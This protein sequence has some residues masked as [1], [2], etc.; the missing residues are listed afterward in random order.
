MIELAERHTKADA[1]HLIAFS[2]DDLNAPFA[3]SEDLY[4]APRHPFRRFAPGIP[5]GIGSVGGG[6][7]DGSGTGGGVGGG[8]GVGW[9]SAGC[10]RGFMRMPKPVCTI[11][12][13]V[14]QTRF[15]LPAI[16]LVA[17]GTTKKSAARSG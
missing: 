7:G 12:T 6:S 4:C 13:G 9:G 5:G 11:N 3:S 17:V 10:G 15:A 8:S 2:D 1:P 16:C 14:T